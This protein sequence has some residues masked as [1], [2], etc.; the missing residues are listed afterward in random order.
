[1]KNLYHKILTFA[2]LFLIFMI[3]VAPTYWETH[4]PEIQH[5]LRTIQNILFWW[6]Q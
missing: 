6:Q 4:R 5:A 3:P 2:C 1:M